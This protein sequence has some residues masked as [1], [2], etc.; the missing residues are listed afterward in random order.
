MLALFV[1]SFIIATTD[2]LDC[3]STTSP[4]GMEIF[5]GVLDCRYRTALIGFS[6]SRSHSM[7]QCR[8]LS[9]LS[10]LRRICK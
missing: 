9:Q 10:I 1:I 3:F 5:D 6:H 4:G 7:Q 2:A 8:V